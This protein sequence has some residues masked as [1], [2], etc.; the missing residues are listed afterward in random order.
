MAAAFALSAATVALLALGAG[1]ASA[2]RTHVFG[3][4]FGGPGSTPGLFNEP[5]G[6]AVDSSTEAV[7]NPAAGDVYVV[8]R[9]N[10]RVERFSA[11]GVYLG[12]FNG[13]G[14]LPGEG[15]AA[16]GGGRP[17]EVP[18]GQFSGPE[19]IA[20]DNSTSALDPSA[21]D[22]YVVDAGHEVI[23]K[24][25]STGAYV[26]QLTQTTEGARFGPLDG[27]AV[28][29]NGRVW[30]FQA[31]KEIDEFSD[32]VSNE[33]I[34]PET[35]RES[36]LRLSPGPGFAADV[37][38][39][40]YVTDHSHEIVGLNSRGEELHFLFE[41]EGNP[42][43]KAS[44]AT[45]DAAGRE[46]Y[47]D[48]M[49]S[50]RVFSTTQAT[51]GERAEEFES[52]GSEHLTDG[53][54]IGVDTAT[55]VVYV[56]DAA[57]NLVDV[58][59]ATPE[60]ATGPPTAIGETT[61]TIT[62][63]V[64]LGLAPVTAC[65]FEYGT[66]TGY[67][68]SVPC[69]QSPAE[70]GSGAA[71]VPVSADLTGLEPRT[72]YHYRL[73][74]SNASGSSAG[75]DRSV[76][77]PAPPAI[78]E[79]WAT[80]VSSTSAT[81]GAF[82]NPG[83]ADTAYRYQ[84]VAAAAYDPAASDPYA[85]GAS[86][87]PVDAGSGLS[88]V[89]APAHVQGLMPGTTYHYRA[90]VTNSQATVEGADH[91]FTTTS[92]PGP[93]ELPDG[94]AWELVSPAH[95]FGA[96]PYGIDGISG[97]GVVQAAESGEAITYV[98]TKPPVPDAPANAAGSQIVSTREPEAWVSRDVTPPVTAPTGPSV[99]EGSLYKA[100]SA[101]L[102]RGLIVYAGTEGVLELSS[103]APAGYQNVWLLHELGTP[104]APFTPV[105]THAPFEASPR[106]PGRI[107]LEEATPDL[108]H[109]VV[110]TYAALTP[111]AKSG[112]IEGSELENLYE[113]SAGTLTAVNV[114]PGVEGGVTTPEA[115]LGGLGAGG[116]AISDDGTR[117]FWTSFGARNPHGLYVRENGVRTVRISGGEFLTA[118]PDGRYAFYS[119][120]GELWRFDVQN[121]TYEQLA[122]AGADV[123]GL[124][125]VSTD[126]DYAYFVANG[127]LATGASL[128]TCERGGSETCSLY[129][130][131][132][133]ETK[134]VATLS[135]ADE[136]GPVARAG[137]LGVAGDWFNELA[138][139]T[140]RVSPDG[141]H[142]VFMSNRSLTGYDNTDAL[143]GQP[144]EEVY[145]YDAIGGGLTCVSCNPSGGRPVGPSGIPPATA[146][147]T[148]DGFY[149]SRV[150]S[151]DG[152]R[153]FFDTA[154]A[155][156]PQDSNG[157]EDVYEYENGRPYLIS[158][159]I[160]SS[161]SSFLDASADGS[162]V[163]FLTSEPLVPEDVDTSYDVYDARVCT[164]SS[165]CFASSASQPPCVSA[166]GC[167][168]G[169]SPQP[170]GFGPPPTATFSGS[171]NP[172][173]L[174]ASK[175]KQLTRAQQLAKALAA[176]RAKH[177]RHRRRLCEAQAH[178]RFG[179]HV[180]SNNHRGGR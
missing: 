105:M 129:V 55:G 25:S 46:L 50:V 51:E 42:E 19:G 140:V 26:G 156:V 103:E 92:I 159:G 97:G 80:Q 79:E 142:V 8:D 15:G 160:S 152:R 174:V 27:V 64:N 118:T 48:N 86:I 107:V 34:R 157:Q 69:A 106:R 1:S 20:V 144:D 60:V 125:G 56:A 177:S 104:G 95:K 87:A 132:H 33:F 123:L 13:S 153:V 172:A 58:F 10:N 14:L 133:G 117:V 119:E 66:G 127:V 178:R 38:G 61:A 135:Q 148:R 94:R 96:E 175:P 4:T 102:S 84:Y 99:G 47:I 16:G 134:F 24:F 85:A 68:Q 139:R 29:P 45:V 62:G 162:N 110:A 109:V 167:R 72:V 73:V 124:L 176:C 155:L 78:H 180:S 32:A 165:P 23:D 36:P 76:T 164:A 149:Q 120:G 171:G 49:T 90:V 53:S 91:I 126:G 179:P 43:S 63:T 71:T 137:G 2:R 28:D 154:D 39:N 18:T 89:S 70:I 113:W 52:I 12:E 115:H 146:T 116:H 141:T 57:T 169:V 9:G 6:V 143:T 131:H 31:S 3:T 166:D 37:E 77:T 170:T 108:S 11:A 130:R 145:L 128:G 59:T 21:G 81:L 54:G 88:D 122:G 44:A 161:P 147:S 75:E 41:P 150:L 163:F 65:A 17:G 35:P 40:L 121:E 136:D 151:N 112:L 114:L 22:V 158:S 93:F 101:D 67:G 100:F 111:G 30:V 7:G 74:V 82:V 98:T 5:S 168:P 83:G 138:G 173:P